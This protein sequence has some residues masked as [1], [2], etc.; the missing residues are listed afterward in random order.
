[1]IMLDIKKYENLQ[2]VNKV[3]G[4]LH[5]TRRRNNADAPPE[6]Q[7]LLPNVPGDGENKLPKALQGVTNE[8][9]LREVLYSENVPAGREVHIS[10]RWQGID[11]GSVQSFTTPIDPDNLPAKFELRDTLT[12]T[13]GERRLS[14]VSYYPVHGA[15][16]YFGPEIRILIDREPPNQG[17]QDVPLSLTNV[18][19]SVIDLDFFENNTTIDISIARPADRATGDIAH[20]YFGQSIPGALVGSTVPALDNSSG[21]LTISIPASLIRGQGEGQRMFYYNWEDRVGNVG[22]ESKEL[23]V[24]VFLTRAPTNLLPPV[25]PDAIGADKLVNVAVSFPTLAVEIGRYTNFVVSVDKVQVEF[26]GERQIPRD[27]DGN[28]PLLV[29]VPYASVK[30]GGVGPRNAR[31]TYEVVRNTVI[32]PELIGETVK[33]DLNRPGPVFPDPEDPEIGNPNLNP[34]VVT[35]RGLPPSGDNRLEM[36]DANLDADATV[37]I[38]DGFK[39]DDHVQLFWNKVLVPAPGGVYEVDGSESAGDPM[40]FVIPWSMIEETS[41]GNW[42]VHYVITNPAQPNPNPSLRAHVSV[43]V[44]AVTLPPPVIQGVVSSGGDDYIVCETVVTVPGQGRVAVVHVNGGAPLA[45]GLEL[46]FT[47]SGERLSGLDPLEPDPGYTVPGPVPNYPIKKTLVGTE[48]LSGFNVYLPF[49]EAL[50]PIRDGK[51]SIVY[52]AIIDG[53]EETSSTHDVEVIVVNANNE[54]CP[55]VANSRAK[56]KVDQ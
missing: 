15:N 1:M 55:V 43:H 36:Q 2:V 40:E 14:Y 34:V 37:T 44:L 16:P 50:L 42:P 54:P 20:I 46:T 10:L 4:G 24:T 6:L 48:H 27:V 31:V 29:E 22:V 9:W 51:G 33:I 47:W 5:K 39:A 30:R 21:D 11:V 25:V 8:V 53:E 7:G 49:A 19:G 17:L 28:W 12:T 18:S 32:V 56:G 52:T 45:E 35:G 13:P 26:D 23:A 3:S 38:F 41:N